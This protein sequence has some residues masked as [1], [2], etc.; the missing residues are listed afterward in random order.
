MLG[1]KINEQLTPR[2]FLHQHDSW[3]YI[4]IGQQAFL[5]LMKS[6]RVFTPFWD[7]VR[8]YGAKFES[9]DENVIDLKSNLSL[10]SRASVALRSS[11][12]S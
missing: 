4:Q 7:I 5:H 11:A 8:G 1:F 2:S 3:D 6:C 12:L 9:K 10:G